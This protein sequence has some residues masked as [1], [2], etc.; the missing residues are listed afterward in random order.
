MIAFTSI[1]VATVATM[2]AVGVQDDY[3]GERF[4]TREVSFDDAFLAV[5]DIV[6]AYS[7]IP[8]DSIAG[9]TLTRISC[10]RRLLR[11]HVGNEEPA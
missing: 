9:S 8:R 6:F 7:E 4:A 11:I 1:V 5:T 2:I 10:T 3:H